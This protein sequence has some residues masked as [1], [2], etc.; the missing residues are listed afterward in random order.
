MDGSFYMPETVLRA[1]YLLFIP[2]LWDGYYS[3]T[4]FIDE[5]NYSWGKL[6]NFAKVM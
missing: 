1:L 6:N 2:I 4:Q 3:Y 5:E